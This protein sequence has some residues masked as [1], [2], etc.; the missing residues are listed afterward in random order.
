[1]CVSVKL[2]G[3]PTTE[4]ELQAGTSSLLHIQHIVDQLVCAAY[5]LV[6]SHLPHDC[7]ASWSPRQNLRWCPLWYSLCLC[8]DN[9]VA[10]VLLL[11]LS[12]LLLLEIWQELRTQ[13]LYICCWNFGQIVYTCLH[14]LKCWWSQLGVLV[15]S[16]CNSKFMLKSDTLWVMLMRLWTFI[17]LCWKDKTLN[18]YCGVVST[19]V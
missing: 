9:N 7:Q 3:S 1:M 5:L 19:I 8:L 2:W 17:G 14:I 16:Q 13:L 15:A 11:V 6:G 4:Q 10:I 18:C 12:F